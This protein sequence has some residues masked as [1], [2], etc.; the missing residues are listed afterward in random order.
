MDYFHLTC[1]HVRNYG[2]G[3]PINQE[4]NKGLLNI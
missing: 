3:E 2:E 4:I 1:S